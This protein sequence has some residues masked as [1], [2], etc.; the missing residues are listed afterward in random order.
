MKAW[1]YLSYADEKGFRG[2]VYVEGD[3]F[4]DACQESHRRQLS[5]GGQVKG[6]MVPPDIVPKIEPHAYRLLTAEEARDIGS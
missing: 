6:A 2:A 5:P 4:L 3:G 1:W